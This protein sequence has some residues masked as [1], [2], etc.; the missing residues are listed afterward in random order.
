MR[1]SRGLCSCAAASAESPGCCASSGEALASAAWVGSAAAAGRPAG[2]SDC[3]DNAA[4]TPASMLQRPRAEHRGI[5]GQAGA[6]VLGLNSHMI[7][8]PPC[9]IQGRPAACARGQ[10]PPRPDIFHL[11]AA[12]PMAAWPGNRAQKGLCFGLTSANCSRIGCLFPLESPLY[13]PNGRRFVCQ[14]D[15]AITNQVYPDCPACRATR[16]DRAVAGPAPMA[17]RLSAPDRNPRGL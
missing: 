15:L 3:H 10:P 5:A 17:R 7:D 1:C 2:A 9:M 6:C 11:I 4:A 13:R 14:E 16:F 12:Y 8:F